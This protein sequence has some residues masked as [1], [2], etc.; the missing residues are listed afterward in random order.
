MMF[1]TVDAYGY[2]VAVLDFLVRLFVCRLISHGNLRDATLLAIQSFGS[3]HTVL[4]EDNKMLYFAFAINTLEMFIFLIVLNT[5]VTTPLL[6]ARSHRASTILTV[7]ACMTWFIRL[8]FYYTGILDIVPDI[9]KDTPMASKEEKDMSIDSNS[10]SISRINDNESINK[11][12]EMA[13]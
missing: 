4:G 5:L 1:F 9:T 7:V 8:V 13:E 2:I 6:Y 12:I 11:D 3:D 10:I